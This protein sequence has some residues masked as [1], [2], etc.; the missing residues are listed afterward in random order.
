MER[1]EGL[2][3]EVTDFITE[4][5]EQFTVINA[6]VAEIRRQT[7]Q[8][9]GTVNSLTNRMEDV[10]SFNNNCPAI[11]LKESLENFRNEMGVWV[12]FSKHWK[13]VAAFLGILMASYAA[14]TSLIGAV[15]RL[16]Q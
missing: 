13:S 9:N 3:K 5:R 4:S 6:E 10:E 7:T 16:V 15:E 14:V 2:N 12:F 8:T 11:N 1:I